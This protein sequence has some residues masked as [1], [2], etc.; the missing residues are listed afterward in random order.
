MYEEY[1]ES[2]VMVRVDLKLDSRYIRNVGAFSKWERSFDQPILDDYVPL[3]T[4]SGFYISP[5]GHI[6]T[7]SH[8]ARLEN[9]TESRGALFQAMRFFVLNDVSEAGL[10]DEEKS[11]VVNDLQRMTAEAPIEIR[12]EGRDRTVLTAEILFHDEDLDFALLK[13]EPEAPVVPLPFSLSETPFVGDEVA[14][15]GYPLSGVFE[16]FFEDLQ[17]T[18]SA[19][20]VSAI[21]SDEWSI[22][23]TAAAN[24][25]S[26]G[27]PLIGSDLLVKG[28]IVGQIT[29]AEQLQFAI[30]VEDVYNVLRRRN[31]RDVIEANR[32]AG[33]RIG[34][35]YDVQPDG[36]LL[37]SSQI[38]VDTIPGMDVRV[39]GQLI[40]TSPDTIRLEAG[41]H[42][43][44]LVDDQFE[45]RQQIRVDATSDAQFVYRPRLFRH[46]GT[47][48]VTTDPSGVDVL[49]NGR[50][51]GTSPYV[52]SGIY[53]GE[54]RLSLES[55]EYFARDRTV[56]VLRNETTD[57]QIDLV[58][59][60]QVFFADRPGNA[61][62]R[63]EGRDYQRAYDP[64]ER[65]VLP[66][67]NWSV[68]VEH[69][70]YTDQ[71]LRFSTPAPAPIDL[72]PILKTG[73]VRLV[74]LRPESTVRL[75]SRMA[76]EDLRPDGTLELPVGERN[77][78]VETPLYQDVE[79]SPVVRSEYVVDL[80]ISYRLT[81]E[82]RSARAR[83]RLP[84]VLAAGLIGSGVLLN[85]D[86]VAVPLTGG[87]YGLYQGFKYGSLALI[88]GGIGS[89]VWATI[90]FIN[91]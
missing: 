7:N 56:A 22:Q 19:G 3:T 26:S 40:A 49:V 1:A 8:V 24:P 30:S 68:A 72:T 18:M 16:L 44:E 87:S 43:I 39:D 89:A 32:L 29:N 13:V 45:S 42:T 36:R 46:S 79:L 84:F 55:P 67:G 91:D 77:L 41:E 50:A 53:S 71:P 31:M 5:D 57:V 11:Q 58:P 86:D 6:A 28:V 34:L 64:G 51:V 17:P 38:V 66:E 65:V 63:V 52:A 80:T 10:N 61:V 47:L 70:D 37:T 14:A 15:I 83:Q 69:R 9:E 62:L 27:G 75:E 20:I 33:Y 81:P 82:A 88:A 76:E 35:Q 78:V 21:R 23:H 48:V 74:G 60:E 73:E 54:Y 90:E 25:G 2:V 12:I 59:A 4:G 85:L